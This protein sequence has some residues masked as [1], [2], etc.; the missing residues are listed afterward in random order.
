MIKGLLN[1]LAVST[2]VLVVFNL[3]GVVELYENTFFTTLWGI[4]QFL[5]LVWLWGECDG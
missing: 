1:V 3:I 4:V 5:G 2:I